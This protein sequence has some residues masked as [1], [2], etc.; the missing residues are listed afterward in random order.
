VTSN[1]GTKGVESIRIRG[2]K[3]DDLPLGQGNQAKEQLPMA[4]EQER[5]NAIEEI[6]A[7][8]PTHRIDYLVSRINECNQ[9]K[10]RM[11]HTVDQQNT[12]INEY[13]G[14]IAMCK[15]RDNELAK[16][17][18]N[19][20]IKLI[21]QEQFDEKRKAL[22]KQYPP[23]NVEAMEQQIV[24]CN[25]AIDRCRDVSRQEDHSIAQFT[26]V[27]VLCKERD[28]KLA[29]HGAKAEGS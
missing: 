6:N 19:L 20:D 16:E 18:A 2:Q 13:K 27:W 9:N 4:I 14:Q 7:T 11:N 23:Y 25:E 5:L 29:E 28:K 1:I 22:F 12:M 15:H 10:E 8:Y 3:I 21:T 24:Q 26:E 17:Q